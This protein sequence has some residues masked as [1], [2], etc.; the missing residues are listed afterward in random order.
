MGGAVGSFSND[1]G[2]GKQDVKKAIGLMSK[3]TT[4]HVH[5][6][7]LYISLLLLHN[8]DVKWPN[9]KFTWEQEQQG[10][11]FYHLSELGSGP[12]FSVP[13]KIPFF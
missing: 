13:T 11:E 4:L 1:D 6:A 2:D 3:P 9:L 7:F 10:E 12:L 5:H 8:Y